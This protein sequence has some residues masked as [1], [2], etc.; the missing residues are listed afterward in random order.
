[1]GYLHRI[2][3]FSVGNAFRDALWRP[4]LAGIG[5]EFVLGFAAEAVGRRLAR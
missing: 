4:L 1:L 2:L 3:V 5:V